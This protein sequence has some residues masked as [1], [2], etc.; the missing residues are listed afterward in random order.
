MSAGGPPW[1]DPEL[2]ALGQRFRDELRAEAEEYERLAA[3]DLLRH[4][5]LG[6]VAVEFVHR[7]D[8]VAV[9][10]GARTFT[11]TVVYAAGDLACLRCAAG[12]VDVRL[13]PP[14]ALRVVE[15]VRSGGRPRGRGP[16]GFRARLLEHEAAGATV[17]FG[18]PTLPADV[19]GR[20]EAVAPDHV[21][22][23]DASSTCYLALSA[24]AWVLL[25]RP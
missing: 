4:R 11:G 25:A 22:V 7:G 10:A 5:S 18:C 14:L 3:R 20:L 16:R 24:I 17:E 6:D 23:A 19:R 21:V 2:A 9:S 13:G 12:D 15:R 1:E 8:V